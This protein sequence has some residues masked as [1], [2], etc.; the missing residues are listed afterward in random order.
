MSHLGQNVITVEEILI[1]WEEIAGQVSQNTTWA[2]DR[3]EA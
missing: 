3:R 1:N 2:S